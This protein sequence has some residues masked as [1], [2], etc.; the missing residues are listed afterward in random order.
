MQVAALLLYKSGGARGNTFY[1]WV[2]SSASNTLVK[3]ATEY[4][5]TPIGACTC[6]QLEANL[7][8][9]WCI[10]NRC[11]KTTYH[12]A[13]LSLWGQ[14]TDRRHLLPTT[15]Y[16]VPVVYD[17]LHHQCTHLPPSTRTR[18]TCLNQQNSTTCLIPWKK[19]RMI[20]APTTT[21]HPGC[22][23]RECVRSAICIVRHARSM[24]VLVTLPHDFH[25]RT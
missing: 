14:N 25:A 19:G 22:R 24:M 12:C 8:C 6:L 20:A 5:A 2:N 18:T 17:M 9:P 7:R 21:N 16:Y 13:F 3:H 15:R 4:T 10:V 23:G 1:L 11:T